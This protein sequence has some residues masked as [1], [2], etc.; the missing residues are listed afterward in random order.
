MRGLSLAVVAFGALA[1]GCTG[2]IS[3]GSGP[4]NS[5][6]AG[7]GVTTGGAGSGAGPGPGTT[8]GGGTS[9]LGTVPPVEGP[10]PRLLRQLTNS[11]YHATV[12]D[13]LGLSAPDTT[14]IPPD[15]SIAGFTTNVTGAFVTEAHLDAYSSVS[16]ALVTRALAES[17]AKII[18]CAT[19]DTACAGAFLD[20][21]GKRA[22]RRPLTAD[23][24][25]RYLKL[26][27]ATLTG[28][29]FDTGL[30]LA[31]RA[32]LVSPNFLFRSELGRDMGG[33]R[34]VLT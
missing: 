18:P 8:G 4:G 6:T 16:T 15:V 31:L 11:E 25:T 3:R 28:G 9:G 10:S 22:F 33:G 12:A 20:S 26:F 5:G 19:K 34:F 1:L 14:A 13:L 29:D 24:K 30:A 2:Q 32:L 21:F 17:R 27:D 7:P 23:E